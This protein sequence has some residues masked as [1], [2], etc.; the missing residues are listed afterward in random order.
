MNPI[1]SKIE[2]KGKVGKFV[3]YDKEKK[4]EVP[5]TLDKFL[6]LK[7]TSQITGYN[8]K[9]GGIWSNEVELIEEEEIVVRCKSVGKLS[10][11]AYSE[12]KKSL[13]AGSKFATNLYVVAKI[14]GVLGI[15]I[16]QMYGGILNE[17]IEFSKKNIGVCQSTIIIANLTTKYNGDIKYFVPIFAIR[18]STET[19]EEAA[20]IFW[21]KL[22]DWQRASVPNSYGE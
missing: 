13:P 14:N 22:K 8:P 7:T 6:V 17:W 20:K 4:E 9:L 19:E 16:L 5:I 3:Y 1:K 12:I 15:Y 11:G 21:K 18:K 10:Q 2:F